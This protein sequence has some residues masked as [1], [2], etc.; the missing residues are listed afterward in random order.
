MLPVL[1]LI[2][3]GFASSA[4]LPPERCLEGQAYPMRQ[5]G[6]ELL[7][8]GRR[9]MRHR[10]ASNSSCL[11]ATR[12]APLDRL[13]TCLFDSSTFRSAHPSDCSRFLERKVWMFQERRCPRGTSF[14]ASSCQC[15]QS[16]T[17]FPTLPK[18]F[19]AFAIPSLPDKYEIE[20]QENAVVQCLRGENFNANRG[21]CEPKAETLSSNDDQGLEGRCKE[22]MRPDGYRNHPTDCSKFYQCAHSKWILMECPEG[23]AFDLDRVRCD[24]PKK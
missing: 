24:H 8:H 11:S 10:V 17:C 21:A 19:R 16:S 13:P 22:S 3:L 5:C 4:L 2:L 9:I 7:C 18:N 20:A 15:E 6:Y 12:D 1:F 14:N 23:L